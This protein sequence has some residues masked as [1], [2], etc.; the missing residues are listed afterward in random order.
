MLPAPTSDIGFSLYL[1]WPKA[2]EGRDLPD[3][4]EH[5]CPLHTTGARDIYPTHHG[6]SRNCRAVLDRDSLQFARFQR[7]R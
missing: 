2:R 4:L 5:T 6:C 3:A 7:D 1:V